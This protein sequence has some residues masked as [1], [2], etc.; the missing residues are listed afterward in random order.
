MKFLHLSDLHI[1]KKVNDYSLL[2]DQKCVLEQIVDAVA[3]EKPD[4]IL[5]SGDVYDKSVPSA[6][7]VQLLDDFLTRLSEMRQKVFVIS[8]NHDSAERI[9]FGSEIMKH[10]GI[11]FSPVYNGSIEPIA[12]ND[13]FGVVNIFMLPFIRPANVRACLEIEGALSY[14][15]AVHVAIENMNVDTSVRNVLMAHQFVTGAERCDS[16]EVIG[17]L[18]NVDADVF[19]CFDY[20]AL[21]HLHRPQNVTDKIRYCGTPLKYSISE[22]NDEKSVSVV[23][24]GRKGELVLREI[25]LVPLRNWQDLRGKYADLLV[26]SAS[27]NDFVR[28]TLTDEDEILNAYANLRNIYPNILSFAYDNRRTRAQGTAG[29][30]SQLQH[31]TPMQL[32]TE[33]YK[34]QNNSDLSEKQIE[35]VQSI[36]N[37]I[38]E[39]EL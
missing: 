21:G 7:A 2:N 32:F 26:K 30:V 10:S 18:D 3:L 31:K 22:L 36:I 8:G 28:I 20:V 13:E 35:Y 11:Y 1:G 12:L 27:T 15:E 23:E 25:P 29:S 38:W 17:G 34:Q 24:L 14:T 37:E 39:D 6:E 16:E 33:F 9:A 5:V 19:D 4:A